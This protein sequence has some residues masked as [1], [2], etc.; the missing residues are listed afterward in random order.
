MACLSE[1]VTP[2]AVFYNSDI[3]SK[4]TDSS[5]NHYE[6]PKE[7]E[8]MKV[9]YKLNIKENVNTTSTPCEE[10]YDEQNYESIEECKTTL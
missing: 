6:E 7:K 5:E 4:S 8:N 1:E 9:F 3:Y 10:E 2:K